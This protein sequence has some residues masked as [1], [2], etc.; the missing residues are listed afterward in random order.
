MSTLRQHLVLLIDALWALV[1]AQGSSF[2]E[3]WPVWAYTDTASD[4]CVDANLSEWFQVFMGSV[5]GAPWCL[6]FS[7]LIRQVLSYCPQGHEWQ[8]CCIWDLHWSWL[9]WWCSFVSPVA[10]S[11]PSNNAR[12]GISFQPWNQLDQDQDTGCCCGLST[13]LC[14]NCREWCWSFNAFTY[15]GMLVPNTGSSEPE[16]FRQIA[17][18]RD[19]IHAL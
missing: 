6:F 7:F 14:S 10:I 16:I 13:S 2:E 4:V 11:F 3:S 8:H 19:C 17:M 9:C 12:L 18:T 1:L 15:L 5:K